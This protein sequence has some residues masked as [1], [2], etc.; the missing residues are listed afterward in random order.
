MQT[1]RERATVADVRRRMDSGEQT[2]GP[3]TVDDRVLARIS[4]G[5][6][7]HPV[8][9]LREVVANAYDADATLVEIHTDRPRFRTIEVHDNGSGMTVEALVRMVHHIGG[10]AKRTQ[11]GSRLGVASGNDPMVSPGGRRLIG[12]IGIGL[13]AVAQLTR[14]FQIITKVAGSDHRLIADVSLSAYTEDDLAADEPTAPVITGSYSIMAAPA[15]DPDA[16]G[17]S[18]VLS[19]VQPA[20]IDLLRS[21]T[22]WDRVESQ[23]DDEPAASRAFLPR[24]HIGRLARGSTDT[25]EV[26]PE[27]PWADGDA[28]DAKF[29]KLY[30][31]V[32]HDM[33]NVARSGLEH[34]LDD[35]LAALWRLGQQL[36]VEYVDGIHPFDQTA[37]LLPRV[38]RLTNGMRGQA[39]EIDVPD[40]RSIRDVTGFR[41][42]YRDEHDEFRVIVDDVAIRRPISFKR[43]PQ[44]STE[45]KRKR[46]L[47]FV[48]SF[49][50]PL[51]SVPKD[52]AGGR[53]FGFEGYFLWTPKVVP[54]DHAGVMVRIAD[55]SGT[56]FDRTFLGY[57][58]R[59]N[60]RLAQ[61]TG[62]IFVEH[63]L[64]AAL[65][66]DRESFN[67]SHP[68][69]KIL[70]GWVHRA[71]RQLATAQKRIAAEDRAEEA[72]RRGAEN[73]DALESLVRERVDAVTGDEPVPVTFS[74]P[75]KPVRDQGPDPG[76]EPDPVPG[77]S[78]GRDL[79][80]DAL[81]TGGGRRQREER[82]HR[83]EQMRAVIQI[84][85]A[86][87]VLDA[88]TPE[89]R[90]RLIADLAAVLG[91]TR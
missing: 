35:Y 5:I 48:G 73:R 3:L 6:Y 53:R 22:L 43:L 52:L 70:T 77:L 31:G 20:A 61:T 56:L 76:V 27:L 68:H 37:P 62:E 13:F 72:A 44:A 36:P 71:L 67:F 54:R 25:Y 39:T 33:G 11:E 1:D 18:I 80:N 17:T 19:G 46:P 63:G 38:F 24:Y 34:T 4:D 84:L 79:I 58:I 45:T 42:P 55:A 88:I 51:D 83:E 21:E 40:G 82:Q 64:D 69:A 9:A 59:E 60:Q 85:D 16:Q 66:I 86:Y 47:L 57:Q 41:A 81:P 78:F 14:S 87:G 30:A 29:A 12:K 15:T 26:P 23:E 8:S 2:K 10:S 89:L 49:D 28:A 91:S 32:V 50:A 90:E 75:D 7:R 74:G 65:N